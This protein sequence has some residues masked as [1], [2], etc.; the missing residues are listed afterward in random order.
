MTPTRRGLAAILLAT[1]AGPALAQGTPAR[2]GPNGGLV[3][4]ADGHPIE[5]LLAGTTLTLFLS[6]EDGRP[7]PSARASGRATVQAGGQT[8]SVTLTPAEPNRLVGTLAAPLAAGARVV[9]NGTLGDGHRVT[10][11]YVL[12]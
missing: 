3:A 8:A 1:S 9:F 7:S 6:G 4:I 2:R 11:R 12:E 5:L 10:A